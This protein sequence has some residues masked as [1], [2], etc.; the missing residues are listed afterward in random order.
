M[1]ARLPVSSP[2]IPGGVPT[3]LAAGRPRQRRPAARQ[4]QDAP[5]RI[6][7]SSVPRWANGGF[8]G[9]GYAPHE[10]TRFAATKSSH[11]QGAVP[12]HPATPRDGRDSR[13]L[14]RAMRTRK[15][16]PGP[17]RARQCCIAPHAA[18]ASDGSSQLSD[19]IQWWWG[20]SA[21]TTADAGVRPSAVATISIAPGLRPACTIARHMPLKVVRRLALTSP[22][23]RGPPLS[24]PISRPPP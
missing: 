6:L 14:D 7:A 11:L 3:G 21:V 2:P 10:P 15:P 13:L 8:E 24:T 22:R 9:G 16:L 1:W 18:W 4:I 23:S 17:L 12:N 5:G 20:Y 19:D